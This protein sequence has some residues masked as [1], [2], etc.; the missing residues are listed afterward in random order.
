MVR[1]AHH[2]RPEPFALSLSKGSP[3][4]PPSPIEGE[5]E[6]VLTKA[7]LGRSFL[8]AGP[9]SLWISS[10]FVLP[11][12]EPCLYGTTPPLGGCPLAELPERR[13]LPPPPRVHHSVFSPLK[14]LRLS[15]PSSVSAPPLPKQSSHPC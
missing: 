12:L 2:N 15:M 3:S 13:Y 6:F 7:S 1:Q 10:P 14:G 4:P 8:Q 9:L 5:G 11:G